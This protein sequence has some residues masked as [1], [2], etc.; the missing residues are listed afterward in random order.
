LFLTSFL[1]QKNMSAWLSRKVSSLNLQELNEIDGSQE[2]KQALKDLA[3]EFEITTEKLRSIVKQ[4]TFEM[5][6]GLERH[7]AKGMYFVELA[8]PL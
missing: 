2:Q 5:Q 4:F 3:R 1:K 8:S 7:G 6:K